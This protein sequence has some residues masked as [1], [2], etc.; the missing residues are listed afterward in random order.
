MNSEK[1]PIRNLSLNGPQQAFALQR[2][3]YNVLNW[4]RGV[5][6]STILSIKVGFAADPVYGMPRAKIAIVGSTLLQLLTRTLPSLIDGLEMLGIFRYNEST[7][8]G[9]FVYG[10]RPPDHWPL[11]FQAPFDYKQTICFNTGLC[12]QLISLEGTSGRGIN[13]DEVIVEEGLLI[14]KEKFDQTI[15]IANRGNRGKWPKYAHHHAVTVVTSM[16]LS[17]EG[18]WILDA[19]KYYDSL[20]YR[21]KRNEL[22]TLIIELLDT[23]AEDTVRRNQLWKDII[24][25]KNELVYFA[26]E[27]AVYYSEADVLDNLINLGWDYI[28]DQKKK[29]LDHIFKVEL[30][31]MLLMIKGNRF[32][33]DLSEANLYDPSDENALDCLDGEIITLS[34][35][36]SLSDKTIVKHQPID[37]GCDYGSRINSIVSGQLSTNG[38]TYHV[39]AAFYRKHPSLISDV[40]DDFCKHFA[41]HSRHAVNYYYDHTALGNDGRS[42]NSYK[43]LVIQAFRRN[44]WEVRE[45]FIGHTLEPEQRYTFFAKVFR[46]MEPR[47]PLILFN[48]VSA[49]Y[50]YNSMMTAGIKDSVSG[51]KKDKRQETL[52]SVD[53]E[54]TTHLSDA[55]DTLIVG[56]F[57]SRVV[58]GGGG[59]LPNVVV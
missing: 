40:V 42:L 39:N 3:K 12:I 46:L 23:F 49:Y 45:C 51:F 56:K 4:G 7:K 34:R 54:K 59:F 37:I 58:G 15:S 29:L 17:L 19:G 5:G 55:V 16:P 43:D 22:A 32:Y 35:L 28:V 31:S 48:K 33:P 1:L 2:S 20:F 11:A 38:K 18:G 24:R 13:V 27:D 44:K 41:G 14:N 8:Q 25:L 57:G 47:I 21:E 9:N 36:G 52:D 50:A 53:Q 6:K 30:L 26:S 10:K